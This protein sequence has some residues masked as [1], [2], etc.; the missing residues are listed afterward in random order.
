MS[1]FQ[2][3]QGERKIH[4]RSK[5]P[6]VSQVQLG[7]PSQ[8]VSHL[9]PL[10]AHTTQPM[11]PHPHSQLPGCNAAGQNWPAHLHG[12]SFLWWDRVFCHIKVM[13]PTEIACYVSGKV[14]SQ[15]E[16]VHF[17]FWMPNYRFSVVATTLYKENNPKLDCEAFSMHHYK[18][19]AP[20]KLYLFEITD[21]R[22]LNSTTKS[23][24]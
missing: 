22:S 4:T 24:I 15:P 7:P 11:F 6:S 5:T 2:W 19:T 14:Y 21:N 8:Q 17:P 3:D 20:T 13:F 18:P 1:R 16:L 10:H 12:L 23:K 9:P